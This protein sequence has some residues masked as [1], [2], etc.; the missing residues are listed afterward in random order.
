MWPNF[1]YSSKKSRK[2]FLFK[3]FYVIFSINFLNE[4]FLIC[5]NHLIQIFFLNWKRNYGF[6]CSFISLKSFTKHVFHIQFPHPS[7]LEY[8][9]NFSTLK[10]YIFFIFLFKSSKCEINS[11][12]CLLSLFF[13]KL[14]VASFFHN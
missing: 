9:L 6:S 5:R 11:K 1:E 13:N 2:S 7:N 12:K 8:H 3:G 4:L 14:N 10:I